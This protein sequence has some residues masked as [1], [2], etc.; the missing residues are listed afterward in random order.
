MLLNL[1]ILCMQR[2][3]TKPDKDK[4]ISC[5]LVQRYAHVAWRLR[6]RKKL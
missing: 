6:Y 1:T 3:P 5:D 2:V 4:K